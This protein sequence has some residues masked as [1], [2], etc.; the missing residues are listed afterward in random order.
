[1][2]GNV[3]YANMKLPEVATRD[4]HSAATI[5][6]GFLK[7]AY[8]VPIIPSWQMHRGSAKRMTNNAGKISTTD[9]NNLYGEILGVR[10]DQW[11]Q[12][13]KR[14][15]TMETTRIANADSWEIVALARWGMAYRDN[16]ASA[17][18]YYV[19]V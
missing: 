6:A 7:M 4:V 3:H 15:M 5:E 16:E 19:G 1:M 14:K 9:S 11:K 17:V 12:A 13:F 2:D 18:T 10:F 8:N